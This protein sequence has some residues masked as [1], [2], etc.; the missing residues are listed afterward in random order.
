MG[1]G[2][3]AFVKRLYLCPLC[4]KTRNGF[5]RIVYSLTQAPWGQR[6]EK[7]G[8]NTI[9][10]TA[11]DRGKIVP[12]VRCR[13]MVE[14]GTESELS[15]QGPKVESPSV[16]RLWALSDL[17]R[18]LSPPGHICH[19]LRVARGRT[20]SATLLSALVSCSPLSKRKHPSDLD[21]KCPTPNPR[22]RVS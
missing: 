3:P 9:L 17:D 21:G 4:P 22:L 12:K 7:V 15:V 14:M 10:S 13:P 5:H 8:K 19:L 6:G 20:G 2:H 16:I 1:Q 18:S 11:K